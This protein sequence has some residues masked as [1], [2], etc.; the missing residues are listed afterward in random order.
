[1]ILYFRT[2]AKLGLPPLQ[3]HTVTIRTMREWRTTF[4]CPD[5]DLE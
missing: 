3:L 1:M 2:L 4:S 5:L